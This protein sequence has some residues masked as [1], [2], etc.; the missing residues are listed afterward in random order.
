MS[1]NT[2]TTAAPANASEQKI[3]RLLE[4]FGEDSKSIHLLSSL[5][6]KDA[7]DILSYYGIFDSLKLKQYDN[8][9]SV[10]NDVASEIEEMDFAQLEVDKAWEEFDSSWELALTSS[11]RSSTSSIRSGVRRGHHD[12]SSAITVTVM[13]KT[14]D[15]AEKQAVLYL[16]HNLN[17]ASAA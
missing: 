13:T 12:S 7:T 9:K 16:Q 17:T 8:I 15:G 10:N 6:D 1:S 2:H 4:A 5:P 11:S 3:E 14:H